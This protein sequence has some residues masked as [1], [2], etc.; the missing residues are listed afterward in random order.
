MPDPQYE[1]RVEREDG[2]LLVIEGLDM[3]SSFIAGDPSAQPGGYDAFAGKGDRARIS[4]D[5][6]TAEA[7]CLFG[8][9]DAP[10]ADRHFRRCITY[11]T[12]RWYAP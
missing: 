11:V 8:G 5:N 4:A 6:V 3:L 1:L 2:E 7:T 10:Q 12:P 9:V